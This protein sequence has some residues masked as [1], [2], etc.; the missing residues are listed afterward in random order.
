MT[1]E[2][3]VARLPGEVAS[4]LR[5]SQSWAHPG[6]SPERPDRR[7]IRGRG[8]T[9]TRS[10]CSGRWVSDADEPGFV[11]EDDCLDPVAQAELGQHPADMCLDRA[12]AEVQARGDLRV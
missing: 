10:D 1:V 2:H 11:G 9:G 5:E 12:L 7:R 3:G 6:H 8:Q 4:E